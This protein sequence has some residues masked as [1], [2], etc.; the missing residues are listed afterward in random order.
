MG[1]VSIVTDGGRPDR[2]YNTAKIGA[3]DVGIG[4]VH[5]IRKA[6]TTVRVALVGGGTIWIGSVTLCRA[7]YRL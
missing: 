3:K 2:G 4:T 1:K 5:V 6:A 7:T